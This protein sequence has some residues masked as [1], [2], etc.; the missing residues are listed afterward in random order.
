MRKTINID[1]IITNTGIPLKDFEYIA[2]AKEYLS[3]APVG[4]SKYL[5]FLLK[6]LSQHKTVWGYIKN[7][8]DCIDRAKTFR[9]LCLD[10]A[11]NGFKETKTMHFNPKTKL[12]YGPLTV[13]LI[14]KKYKL[15]DGSHR[16]SILVALGHTELKCEEFVYSYQDMFPPAEK[17]KNL[18]FDWSGKSVVELGCNIGKLEGYVMGKGAKSYLGYDHKNEYIDEGLSRNPDGNIAV[19]R[20]TEIKSNPDVLVA[21]GVF[22]HLQPE[23]IQTFLKNNP[24]EYLLFENPVGH[25]PLDPYKVR[26]KEWYFDLIRVDKSQVR[27][28]AYGFKY[29][30]ERVIFLVKR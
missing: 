22:H 28:F 13:Q 11:Q 2:F 16:A 20:A 14:D 18:V 7:E 8:Q 12:A 21:L 5:G 6:L 17:L 9:A 19:M 25:K 30:I 23:A 3:G 27:E 4:G 15:I 26:P 29:P 1:Q 10:I 24:S